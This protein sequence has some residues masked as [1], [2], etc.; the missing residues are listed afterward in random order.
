M[1]VVGDLVVSVGC[2]SG[3]IVAVARWEI[4]LKNVKTHVVRSKYHTSLIV[5]ILVIALFCWS[6]P[7]VKD[8]QQ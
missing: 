3:S 8:F 7:I 6:V 5:R 2:S 4:T 1:F